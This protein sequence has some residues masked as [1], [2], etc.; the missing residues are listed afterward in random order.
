MA[1]LERSTLIENSIQN[2]LPKR[3]VYYLE[4]L[5]GFGRMVE[6]E[7]YINRSFKNEKYSL[8]EI[9]RLKKSDFWTNTQSLHMQRKLIEKFRREIQ[10]EN[11]VL[12]K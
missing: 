3:V 11:L 5:A 4:N 12:E 7:K 9:F 1:V 8:I 6:C 10:R 2:F